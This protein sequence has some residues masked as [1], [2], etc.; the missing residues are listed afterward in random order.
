MSACSASLT[1]FRDD[2]LLVRDHRGRGSRACVVT[3]DS[4]TD[5]MSL[6]RLAF[7]ETLF[8]Q[9]RVDAIHVL[10]RDNCWYQYPAM[11]AA[12][13]AVRKVTSGYDR[14]VTYGSSMGGYA[15]LRLAGAVGA[16]VS[17]ALSPQYSIDWTRVRWER[18][19]SESSRAFQDVWERSLPPP[20][21]AEAWVI[22]DPLLRDR[23]HVELLQRGGFSFRGIDI[24]G[25]GHPVGSFLAEAG[26]L[27]PAILDV[28]AGRFDPARFREAALAMLPGS[29]EA[30]LATS[31]R[32]P[33]SRI[34]ARLEL[35]QQA[36]RIAPDNPIILSRLALDL[37]WA[38]RL[39]AAI[40][41]HHRALSLQPEQ[42][43]LLMHLSCSLE[44]AGDVA[45]ARRAME[46][47]CAA[48]GGEIYRPRLIALARQPASVPTRMTRFLRRLGG[49][50]P[51]RLTAADV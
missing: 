24:P 37:A 5:V 29:A 25:G 49:Q 42:P 4:F 2:D 19:W 20:A 50:R 9:E 15:A 8:R 34:V 17:L 14:V 40:A 44:L 45:R 6:D 23:R 32:T 39:D 26:L 12:A 31:S 33:K 11:A 47:A 22:Y 36:A 35:L 1:L 21:L 48:P 28:I 43:T 41:L 27:R 30:L 3:F 51:R 7:G 10:S 18:R 13:D 46:R 16:T 38:G